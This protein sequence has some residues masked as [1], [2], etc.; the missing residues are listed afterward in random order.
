MSILNY[1]PSNKTSA[2]REDD[3]TFPSLESLVFQVRNMKAL[4]RQPNLQKKQK[5]YLQEG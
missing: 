5:N 2:R 1:F 4:W 3:A